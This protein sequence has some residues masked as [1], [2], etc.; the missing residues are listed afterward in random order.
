MTRAAPPRLPWAILAL[1]AALLPTVATGE[2]DAI[3]AAEA[4]LAAG[5][6]REARALA[7]DAILADPDRA[8]AHL[9]QA[10]AA[11]ALGD[12]VGAA[13]A[14]DKATALGLR[15]AALGA[16]RAEALL[17]QNEPERAAAAADPAGAPAAARGYAA[18]IRGRAL[19][20]LGDLA[21]AADA[22]DAA[23]AASPRD[24]QLWTDI[25]RFRIATGERAGAVAAADR[26]VALAPR[27]PQALVLKGE[28]ARDQYGLVA[29]LPW[30]GRALAIDGQNVPALLAEA[31]TLGET[32]RAQE[33]LAATRAVL[34]L[35]PRN[36]R[37]WLIQAVI[38]ARGGEWRLARTL[39]DRS[40]GL[41]DAEPATMLLA[42]AVELALGNA[43]QAIARLAPLVA[44]QPDNRRAR[45]LLAAA[46]WRAGGG[47][48]AAATLAPIAA[49]PD[50]DSYSLLLLGRA[51]ERAGRRA[52]AAL[53]LDRGAARG[54]PAA[55]AP[56]PDA[57]AVLAR[58]WAAAPGDGDAGTALV[59]ALL[60][61]GRGGEAVPVAAR[62]RDAN[63]GAPQA[64]MLLGDALIAAGRA[65][66]AAD[67]YRAA[68]NISFT[69]PTA[70][71]LIGALKLAGRGR[72]AFEVLNLF[73]GQNPRN[74]AARMLAADFLLGN[75]RA[76]AGRRVLEALQRQLGPGDAELQRALAAARLATGD[77]AGAAGAG[78]EAYRLLRARAAITASYGWTLWAGGQDRR[79]G[80]ALL[81][82]A[83]RMA[84]DDKG[85]AAWLARTRGAWAG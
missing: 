17:L 85:I 55:A 22:F 25:G 19:T 83:A 84:P 13:A 24:P 53:F 67:A 80:A 49:E 30:F 78:G 65:A 26:A 9:V 73:L 62:V 31:A 37:A 27:L 20:V 39:L 74:V 45:R 23:L 57:L 18:R 29:S 10:R 15:P 2:G 1:A 82:E 28:L 43:E 3:G 60:D 32:G 35:E 12:G 50:A 40:G 63:P 14:L 11:L 6:P 52:E 70:M 16:M 42:G 79:R 64:H 46:Q 59:R 36:P 34:A 38:A 21:G 4:A 48:A 8:P 47:G 68:A 77:R 44:D 5:R 51:L 7:T 71:R 72:A 61:G 33:A 76:A 56:D 66:E 75:G 69:E 58:G 54:R 41:L 81:R